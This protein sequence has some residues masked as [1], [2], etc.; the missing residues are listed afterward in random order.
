[1]SLSHY[2]KNFKFFQ[3]KW[4]LLFYIVKKLINWFDFSN[5]T[6]SS[7]M[8]HLLHPCIPIH[9]RRPDLILTCRPI[10][11]FL[12]HQFGPTISPRQ[13]IQPRPSSYPTKSAPALTPFPSNSRIPCLANTALSVSPSLIAESE[14]SVHR[15]E[16]FFLCGNG[17]SSS[18]SDYVLLLLCVT[19][20][21]VIPWLPRYPCLLLVIIG[22]FCLA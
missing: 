19:A 14:Y 6:G 13:P 5:S 11:G 3:I 8:E 17:S 21:H 4:T 16:V 20:L 7:P 18:S 2:R 12:D 15:P 1:M 9:L 22:L 10:S